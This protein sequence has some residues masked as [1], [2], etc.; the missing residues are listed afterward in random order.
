MSKNI[1]YQ[2]LATISTL[3]IIS[4][5]ATSFLMDD[6]RKEK[7]SNI[8]SDTYWLV[9]KGKISQS[10]GY[11][12]EVPIGSKKKCERV[13]SKALQKDNWDGAAPNAISGIC[14]KG[15]N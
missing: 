6:S 9:L 5:A 14:L 7:V 11:S 3:G 4:L 1:F 2:I 8:N 15:I 12:W 10:G 13:K